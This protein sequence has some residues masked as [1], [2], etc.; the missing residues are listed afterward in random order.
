VLSYIN[1]DDCYP[2]PECEGLTFI[3]TSKIKQEADRDNTGIRMIIHTCSY[4]QHQTQ[5]PQVIAMT[6][7]SGQLKINPTGYTSE[8]SS[9]RKIVVC[10]ICGEFLQNVPQEQLNPHI[11]DLDRFAQ[12]KGYITLEGWQCLNC[13]INAQPEFAILNRILKFDCSQCPQCQGFTFI[14]KTKTI[15]SATYDRSGKKLITHDCS[16]CHHHT[17]KTQTIPKKVRPSSSSSGGYSS[18]GGSSGGGSSGGGGGSSGG[19]GA[20]GSW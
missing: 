1:Q 17:E 12:N 15:T 19:G 6:G 2:C 10:K 8:Y 16:Y 13:E 4:C 5:K 3:Q 18:G 20:G 14:E 7:V 9:Q 11:T